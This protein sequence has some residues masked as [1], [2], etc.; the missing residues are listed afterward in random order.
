[1]IKTYDLTKTYDQKNVIDAITLSIPKNKIT[2]IIGPNGAGKSTLL[3][4]MSRTLEKNKGSVTLEDVPLE[5][6]KSILLAQRLAIMKQSEQT[7][8]RITV[9]DF[10]SFG[11]Y[12][13]SQGR[14]T[15]KD[16]SII[17]ECIRYMDLDI[18]RER[19]IDQLSGGQRQRTYIAAI[20]AQGTDYILLD[21]PL[22]NLDMKYASEMLKILRRLVEER[23]K[24]IVIVIHDINFAACYSDHLILLKEGKLAFEGTVSEVMQSHVLEAIYEMP[25]KVFEIEGK[26]LCAYY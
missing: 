7:S 24:T 2:S 20:L 3:G 8:L 13:Y 17:D 26:T 10:V 22:N 9:E 4:M 11:R 5:K 16:Q 25:F 18:Y 15:K 21:E 19:F 6:Y 12:P 14:L 1:M 23:G